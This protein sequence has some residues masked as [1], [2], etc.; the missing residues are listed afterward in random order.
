MASNPSASD[1]YSQHAPVTRGAASARENGAKALPSGRLLSGAPKG[2]EPR[3]RRR[4][5]RGQLRCEGGGGGL[6][7]GAL[8][9][10]EEGTRR[11][12]QVATGSG[13]LRGITAISDKGFHRL[14]QDEK[15]CGR[16]WDAIVGFLT[17]GYGPLTAAAICSPQCGTEV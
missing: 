17:T 6:L 4:L 7:A 9:A 2:R 5:L 15:W 12:L 11:R 1:F 16:V 10:L 13:H 14:L 8:L 3:E